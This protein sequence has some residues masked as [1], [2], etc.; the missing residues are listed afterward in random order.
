MG[1]GVIDPRWK[2]VHVFLQWSE[3]EYPKNKN[4]S[5]LVDRL[6]QYSETIEEI[7]QNGITTDDRVEA[8]EIPDDMAFQARAHVPD[9]IRSLADI[10]QNADRNDVREQARTSLSEAT[11]HLPPASKKMQ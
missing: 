11:R 7:A 10:A 1:K 4:D 5:E 9:A 2:D 8:Q 3:N 6:K